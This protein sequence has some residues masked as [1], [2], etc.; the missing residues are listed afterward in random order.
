MN[1]YS[2][3]FSL[4]V[5]LFLNSV[6]FIQA[7]DKNVILST[8]EWKPYI[9]KFMPYYGPLSRIVTEAFALEGIKV[10]YLFF[11]W[12]R[13]MIEAQ[14]GEVDGTSSWGYHE[15]R[16]NEFYHSD[17]VAEQKYAFFHLKS[18]KFDWQTYTDLKKIEIGAT[19]GNDYHAEFQ[20]AEADGSIR[21]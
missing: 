16:L 8:G 12:K 5:L 14:N 3:C 19:A 7:E 15:K 4:L 6:T 11:P 9:S 13:S 10:N 18:F 1:K 21:V 20:N 2:L 17:K